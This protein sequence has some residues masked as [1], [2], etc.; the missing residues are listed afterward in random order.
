MEQS[1]RTRST[2]EPSTVPRLTAKEFI[3]QYI[4]NQR[5]MLETMARLIVNRELELDSNGAD[6]LIDKIMDE[7]MNHTDPDFRLQM[8]AQ[9]AIFL[10]ELL[11]CVHAATH[12]DS[13][14]DRESSRPKVS[15]SEN[16]ATITVEVLKT[17]RSIWGK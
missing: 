12:Q 17:V 13:D 4:R 7:W 16:V 3:R 15:V 10:D 5:A 2:S 1:Q 14:E 8:K 9:A 11:E 6:E